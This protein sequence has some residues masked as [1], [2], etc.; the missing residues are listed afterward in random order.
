MKLRIKT[1]TRRSAAT[2]IFDFRDNRSVRSVLFSS[3]FFLQVFAYEAAS[4]LSIQ[5]ERRVSIA[6][7]FRYSIAE[8]FPLCA[9]A[10]LVAAEE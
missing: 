5:L 1:S 3:D 7:T 4:R 8:I 2:S 10:Q 6:E 9:H